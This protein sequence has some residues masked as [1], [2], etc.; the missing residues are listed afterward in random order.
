LKPSSESRDRLLDAA[1]DVIR[2]QGYAATTVDDICERAQLTKGSFFHHFKSKEELALLAVERWNTVTGALFRSAEFQAEPNPLARI[3]GYLE[4]RAQLLSDE[5]SEFTC[6][7]GTLIQETY[8]SHPDIRVA[9]DEGLASHVANLVRDLELAKEKYVP[10]ANFTA[11]SL[12]VLIQAVL[13]GAFIF[14][15]AQMDP[16]PVK[17]SLHH[18]HMY[19]DLLFQPRLNS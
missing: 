9:C 7:L 1:L 8:S 2:L 6:L 17:Q 16:D 14:A 18:L 5:P 11:E 19:L 3:H 12:G 10:D 13:Q 15:K 4:F